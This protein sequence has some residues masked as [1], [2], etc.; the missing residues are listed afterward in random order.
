MCTQQYI[1]PVFKLARGLPKLQNQSENNSLLGAIFHK[2]FQSLSILPTLLS[3]LPFHI[4]LEAQMVHM[5]N[6]EKTS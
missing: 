3:D 5:H 6:A 2:N 1:I 4:S